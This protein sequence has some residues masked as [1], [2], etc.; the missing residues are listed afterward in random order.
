MSIRLPDA[1]NLGRRA[2]SVLVR[3]ACAKAARRGI[4]PLGSRRRAIGDSFYPA[5]ATSRPD[6]RI[7]SQVRSGSCNPHVWPI[8]LGRRDTLE[9]G[10]IRSRARY[11][12]QMASFIVLRRNAPQLKRP[13]V[14]PL[15]IAGAVTASVLSAITLAALFLNPAYRIG[16]TGPRCG[17]LPAWPG[18]RCTRATGSS[19]P[20]RRSF[21]QSLNNQPAL[22]EL[23]R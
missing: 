5:H 22:T 23:P 19:F 8:R 17:L 13:Y 15:G 21:A 14:S 12:L 11:I 4:S 3:T 7:C 6:R 9:Y 2:E 18:L 16:V 10:R 20:R 1:H